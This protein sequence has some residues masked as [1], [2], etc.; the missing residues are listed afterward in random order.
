MTF[1]EIS[2][3]PAASIR[4]MNMSRANTAA[5]DLLIHAWTIHPDR[6]EWRPQDAPNMNFWQHEF[7][8]TDVQ[9]MGARL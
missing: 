1:K 9:P 3:K 2:T 6:T 7:A 4:Q 5:L 8:W